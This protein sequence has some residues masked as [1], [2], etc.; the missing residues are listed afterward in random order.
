[1]S[2]TLIIPIAA[3]A[4]ISLACIAGENQD[5]SAK[6]L[7][8]ARTYKY[9]FR[10][11]Q[12]ERAHDALAVL[13][14]AVQSTPDNVDVLNELGTAYFMQLTATANSKGDAQSASQAPAAALAAFDRALNIDPSNAY[15]R[16]GRGMARTV[17]ASKSSMEEMQAA[18]SDLNRSVELAP[19]ATPVRL[20]RAFSSLA[21]PPLLRQ[22]IPVAEDLEFLMNVAEGTRAGDVVTVLLADLQLE[23][24]RPQ[25][26][27]RYYERV[28][29]QPSFGGEQ[30]RARLATLRETQTLPVSDIAKLRSRIGRECTMCHGR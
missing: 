25:E 29:S 17:I 15:A 3:I 30:A 28:A 7:F 23:S 14:A 26:A 22:D 4:A 10:A 19:A 24:G 11:G 16:A 2:R 9:Q 1:M 12:Y 27:Q 18:I 20:M 8:E 6:A 5:T 21:L 13:K